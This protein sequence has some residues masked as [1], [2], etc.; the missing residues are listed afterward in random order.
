MK[1]ESAQKAV[2]S[3]CNDIEASL[4]VI[5][6]LSIDDDTVKRDLVLYSQRFPEYI[7]QVCFNSLKNEVQFGSKKYFIGYATY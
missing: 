1:H 3:F 6:G 4:A 2:W 5:M 7:N